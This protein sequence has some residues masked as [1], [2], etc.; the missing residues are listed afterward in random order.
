MKKSLVRSGLLV[1]SLA[2]LVGYV[3]LAEGADTIV[4]G[5]RSLNLAWV[6]GGVGSIVVCWILDALVLYE[7]C[8]GRK[9]SVGFWHVV[10]T[11]RVGV[12]MGLLSPMQAAM[13][14]TQMVFLLHAGIKEGVSAAALLWKNI[15][16][17]LSNIILMVFC[18]AVRF[19]WVVTL[20][21]WMVVLIILAGLFNV[22]FM[23]VLI[24]AGNAQKLIIHM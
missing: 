8:G 11:A 2:L 12:M 9:S 20:P 23:V 19:D 17:V 5:L 15:M 16:L 14:P 24:S 7:T 21:T 4:Q 13:V 10:R 18:F 6:V 22:I 1:F 3:L